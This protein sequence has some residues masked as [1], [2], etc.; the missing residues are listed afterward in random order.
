[1][2]R[3]G[4][5]SPMETCPGLQVIP[6][7]PAGL[8]VCCHSCL[9]T[10]ISPGIALLTAK[11]KSPAQIAIKP[12]NVYATRVLSLMAFESRLKLTGAHQKQIYSPQKTLSRSRAT[13][14]DTPYERFIERQ[15]RTRDEARAD[16]GSLEMVFIAIFGSE[17]SKLAV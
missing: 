12:E 17:R 3:R 1:M 10:Q 14:T 11:G 16:S 4:R 15:N 13:V 8:V 6:M 2:C 5:Q 7:A 9:P